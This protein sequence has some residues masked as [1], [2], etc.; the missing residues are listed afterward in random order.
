MSRSPA[1]KAPHAAPAAPDREPLARRVG[2]A[3]RRGAARRV[4]PA[5]VGAA[6]ALASLSPG[7]ARASD[8]GAIFAATLAV[9]LASADIGFSVYDAAVARNGELPA[10]KAA[11]AELIV[12]LP[13]TGV[14]G[15]AMA[16]FTG[17]H[18]PEVGLAILPFAIFPGALTAHSIWALGGYDVGPSTLFFASPAIASDALLTASALTAMFGKRRL[19]TKE[20]GIAETLIMAP[21][22]IAGAYELGLKDSYIPGWSALTAWSGVLLIHGVASIALDRGH[23]GDSDGWASPKSP[24]GPRVGRIRPRIHGVGPAPIA[25][26]VDR[27][28]AYGVVA[29]G[30]F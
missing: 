18:E 11:V 5:V 24:A 22:V 12:T 23:L 30:S 8:D 15:G 2:G 3:R 27:P 16:T 7:T 10:N 28:P 1:K 6:L 4:A 9:L 14:L 21:Q 19:F 20:M 13:Q 25:V 26:S 29:R 17:G